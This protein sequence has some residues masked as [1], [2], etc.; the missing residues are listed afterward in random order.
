[1]EILGTGSLPNSL[2]ETFIMLIPK[3]HNPENVKQFRPISLCNVV[4]K[5]IT[6]MLVNRLKNVLLDIIA[7]TQ[8]NFVLGRQIS[9][10]IVIFQ[11]VIHSMQ[12]KRVGKGMTTVK[13][14]LEK[15]YDRLSWNFIKETLCDVWLSAA[16][17]RNIM[18]CVST[19]SMAV[20]WNG[21]KLDNFHPSR[22]MRHD[23]PISP[24]L[25]VLCIERLSHLINEAVLN[26]RWK[27]IGYLGEALTFRICV[28]AYD[29]MLFAKAT[30]NQ[31]QVMLDY[32]NHFCKAR[33][34]K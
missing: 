11:E 17:V 3:V 20:L 10:N 32:L 19:P 6:K 13:I 1:M 33:V 28:F 29:M 31:M 8:C 21:S 22:G 25:F 7:P 24:Y 2:N 5:A 18:E 26:G 34:R 30:K 4:Y 23:D 14:D 9:D 16:W 12:N 15:A 27:P